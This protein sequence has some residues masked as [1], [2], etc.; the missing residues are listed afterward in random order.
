MRARFAR[1]NPLG[2][3]F[4]MI[5]YLQG[6]LL[7]AETDALI[8][9]VNTVG[10]MGKG[11]ALQFKD[12]FP[13]NYAEYAAACKGGGVRV[14]EMF[15]TETHLLHTPRFII[16]FPTKKDWKHPSKLDYVT[17]GLID[18]VRVI[19]ERGIRSVAVPPLGCGNGG[20]DWALVKPAIESALGELD[21]VDCLVFEP[22][23]QYQNAPKRA[24]V[25]ELT[26]ARAMLV[27]IVRSY[28]VLG[29]ECT[30][31]ELQ[32][33]A[34]FLQRFVEAFN[35]P[36]P[37]KLKFLPNKYGPYADNLRHALDALDGSYLHCEKRLADAGPMEP[38]TVDFGRVS[39]VA[40]YL[41]AAEGAQ[42]KHALRQT[43]T[44]I[45]GFQSPYLMEL[46]STVDWIQAQHL[47]RKLTASEATVAIAAWP[48]GNGAGERKRKI[49]P[50]ET[51]SL[52]LERLHEHAELYA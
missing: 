43:E 28:S 36:N 13:E 34:Y 7:D 37:L 16:N 21:G 31:L 12:A 30:N 20:L 29:F 11:I 50:E 26:P 1:E 9:T 51:V 24:G 49:F 25:E 2:L 5:S 38:I 33:L 19:R 39:K 3:V 14:G 17:R 27:E 35:L 18:L 42:F 8:N 23:A 44:L 41:A 48:G 52:A 45:D 22:T 40:A 6:N 32:K 47:D 4:L 46:L 15:V 10:V